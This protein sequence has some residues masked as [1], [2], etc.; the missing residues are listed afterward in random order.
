MILETIILAALAVAQVAAAIYVVFL[1]FAEIV[2]W[3]DSRRNLS[4][5][6]RDRLGFTLQ[7]MLNN[8]DY[9]TVQGVFNKTSETV[10]DARTVTSNQVD[11][12][13]SG[14]HRGKRLVVYP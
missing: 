6:D 12:Q 1:T 8:G 14:Y 11:D 4:T 9:R 10:E 13:L 3:F 5:V 2:N 7:D